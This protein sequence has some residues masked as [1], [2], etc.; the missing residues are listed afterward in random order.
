MIT[1]AGITRL[2]QPDKALA[3]FRRAA[4][5]EP[6]R[7]RYV[8]VYAVALHSA[9]R[10]DEAMTVLK[11]AF[12][13]HPADRDILLALINFNREAGNIGPALEYAERLARIAVGDQDVLALIQ[14]LRRQAKKP[15]AQ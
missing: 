15:E 10:G 8:Y 11:E 5:L 2:K 1:K 4:E 14:E 3:E 7:A 12:D 9:G 13:K 6:D